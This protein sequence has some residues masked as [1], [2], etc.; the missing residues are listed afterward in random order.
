[1]PSSIATIVLRGATENYL[2]DFERAIDDGVNV[3]RGV[4]KDGR[5]V[6]G[7]G[8]SEI[9]LASALSDHADRCTGLEQYA[10]K[11]YAE[12]LEVFPRTLAENAGMNAT[13]VISK[14]YAAHERG[15][16]S[17]GVNLKDADIGAHIRLN[18]CY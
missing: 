11:K 15:E 18:D 6:P 9:A 10:I 2:N 3:V 17:A 4:C 5:F 14:L 8:A 12:A 1:M 16:G 13:D 7:A